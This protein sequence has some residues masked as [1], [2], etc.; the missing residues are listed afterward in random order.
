MQPN[1]IPLPDLDATQKLAKAFAPILA[2]GDVI[3]LRGDL[4]AG[5]TEFARA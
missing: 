2:N 4:G 3:A 5:K 1:D